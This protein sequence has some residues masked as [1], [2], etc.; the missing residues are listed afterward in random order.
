M[1]NSGSTITID[2]HGKT[3]TRIN[4]SLP[5]HA[6]LIEVNKPET[7]AITIKGDNTLA[8]KA[9]AES[10]GN[11]FDTLS[12]KIDGNDD[13]ALN[14]LYSILLCSNALLNKSKRIINIDCDATLQSAVILI[15][16]ELT[17]KMQVKCTE[18][19][20]RTN[21]TFYSNSISLRNKQIPQATSS[22]IILK[23]KKK[24]YIIGP[25]D[26]ISDV[27][28]VIEEQTVK[29]QPFDYNENIYIEGDNIDALH[30]LSTDAKCP[31]IKMI[32]ID[33]PYNTGKGFIYND[34]YGDD[35][36]WTDFMIPRL[37]V[38]RKILSDSGAIFISIDFNELK[39]LLTICD[40]V[41]GQEN[42]IGLL[43][44]EN[45]PKGRKNSHHISVSNDYC[46]IYAKD[47][48]KCSFVEN[49]PKDIKDMTEDENGQ[50]IH[51][52]GKRV[53][54]GKNDFNKVVSDE[55]SDKNYSVWHNKKTDEISFEYHKGWDCYSSTNSRGET[56]ENTYSRSR[57]ESLHAKGGLQFRNGKIYEKNMR[58]H[59]RI[60]SM[61]TN[62]TYES[63]NGPV[64]IDF[65]TT[66]AGKHLKQ[67]FG[68]PYPVFTAPKT[69]EMMQLLISLFPDK[70]MTIMDFFSG[71]ATMGEA[72]EMQNKADGGHRK[73]ILVQYPEEISVEQARGPAKNVAQAAIAYLSN[74]G[75]PLNLCE[76]G[77]ER[78]RLAG[79]RFKCYRP[80]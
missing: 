67:L 15:V 60:K 29:Y 63:I 66:S 42:F 28:Y 19:G 10:S 53:L 4:A 78:L 39:R 35:S 55:S 26:G 6:K 51:G 47:I 74:A 34:H 77:K 58:T 32:Y 11:S 56:I 43:S 68:T 31:K 45:N 38:A 64:N 49:I 44:I 50:Y 20:G 73:F 2:W 70:D 65:K 24:S 23:D 76:I 75:L 57:I 72:V 48:D 71:S 18:K 54:V 36:G 52:S 5:C 8:L 14:R 37:S 21:M 62:R 41:F 3:E 16:N 79:V 17:K 1:I 61:L 69:V 46:A 22:N 25:H 59:T 13:E 40:E 30:I 27:N 12:V 80:E 9:L 7:D 33:P